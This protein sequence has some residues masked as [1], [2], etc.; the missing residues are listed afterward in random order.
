MAWCLMNEQWKHWHRGE[1]NQENRRPRI[2]GVVAGSPI[3]SLMSSI[4]PP[5]IARD[6]EYKQD[7]NSEDERGKPS[8]DSK[9]DD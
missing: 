2:G 5:H 3:L 9:D 6:D 8:E 7:A 1:D 4:L